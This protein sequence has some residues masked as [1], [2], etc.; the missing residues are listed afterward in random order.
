MK[1]VRVRISTHLL[2]DIF[3]NENIIN[4]RIKQGLP[5]G[6]R[7]CYVIPSDTYGI[8]IVVSHESFREL[9]DGEKIP[10]FPEIWVEKVEPLL[11][12]NK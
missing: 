7:F 4:V 10:K 5:I 1:Y 2:M 8:D 12:E 9:K 6:C 11:G 3:T